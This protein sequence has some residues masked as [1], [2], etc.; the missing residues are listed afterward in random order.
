MQIEFLTIVNTSFN[1]VSFFLRAA[2]I[3][4]FTF[5]NYTSLVLH[6]RSLIIKSLL[7]NSYSLLATANLISLTLSIN[8]IYSSPYFFI[9]SFFLSIASLGINIA[10]YKLGTGLSED[11]STRPY[12]NRSI[13][14][15]LL[16]DFFIIY[17]MFS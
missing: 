2:Y 9:S 10:S 8:L 6:S 11:I 12:L 3:S 7:F 5:N 1:L 14:S 13:T 15:I 17:S 16:L 4:F